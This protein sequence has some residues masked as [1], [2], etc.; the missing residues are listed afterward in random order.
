MRE[1]LEAQEY[2]RLKGLKVD[3][4]VLNE[5]PVSYMDEVQ[6]NL[7]SLLDDGPWRMWKHQPGGVFLLRADVMGHTE[8]MLFHA[9][10]RAVVDTGRGDLRAHLARPA[11]APVA[12]VPLPVIA[13]KHLDPE[14]LDLIPPAWPS[15]SVSTP[16]LTLSNGLGGF[17]DGGKT[18]AIVLDGDQDTPAPWSNVISNPSFGTVVSSSGSATTWSE[19]SRENRLTPVANDPVTD[20]SGEA[21]YLRDDDTGA[22]WSPTPGPMLRRRSSGRFQIRHG[23]G[24]RPAS[25]DRSRAFTS[26]L[27]VFVDA[28]EPVKSR[29]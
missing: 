11:Q 22:S 8:R 26:Q 28:R 7:T 23:R 2:W 5:H 15:M 4:V 6:S 1:T 27:E 19:N 16:P 18:Y 29:S 14:S 13:E 12:T 10:A 24:C 3:L 17:A 9:V 21:L 20:P 25:R